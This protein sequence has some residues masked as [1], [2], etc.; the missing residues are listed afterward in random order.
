MA[1]YFSNVVPLDTAG[2]YVNVSGFSGN[3]YSDFVYSGPP[4]EP[5]ASNFYTTNRFTFTATEGG[6]SAAQVFGELATTPGVAVVDQSYAP[7]TNNIGTGSS[8]PHP[9]VNTGG[10]MLLTNPSNGNRTTVT[11]IGIMSQSLV[12]GVFVGPATASAL[13]VSQ[14]EAFF[15]TLT[16]GSSA[17]RAAQVAKA[18]FFPYG[19]VVLNIADILAT[20]IASTEG[21]IGLLQIF[22]GLGLAV[23]IAAMGIVA[24]R[25][26]VERRREIGMIR[27]NGFTQRMV[28]KA[29]FL[30]YTFVALV[31]IAIGTALGLLIVWNLTQGPSATTV[32][33]TTFTV[34]WLNLLIIL[35]VAYGLAMLAI[36]GPS[37]RAA[38]MSPA[39]A[40]R[41]TE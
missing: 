4:E 1:P 2:I 16:P 6:M 26:V 22:V 39:E 28:L 23:G 13:G 18:A 27:A 10:T 36:V 38:R 15:L 41:P 25:A 19:L 24:L 20:S 11:V 5:A 9:K 14:P 32:G 8:A 29:F 40:V 17:T 35:G 12:T 21:A 33:V 37:L 34:P 7:V 30:E 31:G 3:P